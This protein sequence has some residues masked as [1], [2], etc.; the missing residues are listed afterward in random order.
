MTDT[1]T[2]TYNPY[3]VVVSALVAVLASYTALQL[4]AQLT[5]ARGADRQLS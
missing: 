5:A 1:L 4:A 2:G 3:I